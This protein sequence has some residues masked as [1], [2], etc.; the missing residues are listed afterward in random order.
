M[1]TLAELEQ[2]VEEAGAIARALD[3][4]YMALVEAQLAL[5]PKVR[6]ATVAACE[7]RA[8]M[9]TARRGGPLAPEDVMA[10]LVDAGLTDARRDFTVEPVTMVVPLPYQVQVKPATQ[11]GD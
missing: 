7:A 8:A 10:A 6:A 11:E 5:H 4:E 9:D 2:R 3:A 1:T